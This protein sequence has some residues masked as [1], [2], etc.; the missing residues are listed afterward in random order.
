MT[1]DQFDMITYAIRAFNRAGKHDSHATQLSESTDY[2]ADTLI[3]R[4]QMAAVVSDIQ[5]RY[6]ESYSEPQVHEML[7]GGRIIHISDNE[8]KCCWIKIPLA[9]P[10]LLRIGSVNVYAL[11][12]ASG[13]QKPREEN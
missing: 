3:D 6:R 2:S 5:M 8:E 10:E 9:Y 12:N 11:L 7:K 1:D 4:K 13:I